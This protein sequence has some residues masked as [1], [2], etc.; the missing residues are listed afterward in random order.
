[1]KKLISLLTLAMVAGVSCSVASAKSKKKEK[2][3]E[4]PV[5]EVVTLQTQT[6][7]L[8]YAAGQ[9]RTIGMMEFVQGQL[10][11]DSTNVNI[12]IETLRETLAQ[13][14]TPEAKAKNAAYYIASMIDVQMLPQLKKQLDGNKVE[15]NTALFKRGFMDAVENDATI[16][17][18]DEASK[19]YGRTMQ[20]LL[21][22]ITE[23]KKAEGINWLAQN[24]TKEGVQVTPSGLQYKVVRQGNGPVA[25]E[26][27]DVEVKYEG[28]LI[29]G[30]IF[31]SSYKRDPQTTT[32]KPTQVIKGWT[33]ALCM[34]PEGS[35]W[36]LYI[37]YD[38]AYGSRDTG[39][40]PAYS[41]LIFKVEV[42][43]VTP[44]VKEAP[45]E[46]AK[47]AAKKAPAKKPVAKK[48]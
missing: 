20:A 40:I 19:Y 38:L 2:V 35:E 32:F 24:K 43:K 45:A 11:V 33:E 23:A 8:N 29:D 37:P 14:E 36:E 22:A 3:V 48:K 1:M 26:N 4:A 5:K 46:E 17:S 31:D 41:T 30:T 7:T 9:S 13:P 16:M 21:D 39:S 18:A 27:A 15:M 42:V 34:M 12:F 47:P 28:K 44:E 6:D 25:T 10:G